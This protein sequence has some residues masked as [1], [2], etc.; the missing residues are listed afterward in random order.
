MDQKINPIGNIYVSERAI[1]TIASQSAI[2]S[3]GVIM[4]ASKNLIEGAAHL[5]INN[6]Q[7]GVDIH[8]QDGALIV[9]LYI[10]I[11]YGVRI[12]SVANSISDAVRYQV[13][14]SVGIPVTQVNI[15]VRGLRISDPD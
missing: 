10:I 9:D 11:E 6:P 7:R 13:E 14:K 1:S 8:Y 5:F 2:E 4:L 15:H 12:T 3:Y